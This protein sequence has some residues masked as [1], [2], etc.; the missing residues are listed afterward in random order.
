MSPAPAVMRTTIQSEMTSVPPVTA[1]RSPPTSR[2]TGADS[3]VIAAS[4]TEATPSITSPSD[5]MRSPASTKTT[6]PGF[7]CIAGTAR[8]ADGSWRS[9]V[10][11]R[12]CPFWLRAELAAWALP[13]PSATASAK[14]ANSTVNHSQRD[15]LDR[16]AVVPPRADDEVADEKHRGE[17]RPRPRRR[18]SPGSSTSVTRVEFLEGLTDGRN[19]DLGVRDRGRWGPFACWLLQLERAW[20][21]TSKLKR[22]GRR[23]SRNARRSG[24]ARAP[25]N[26]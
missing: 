5:G 1:E 8:S 4:F 19:Q 16:K 22:F 26:R 25:G 18:T 9:P 6:S 13:R 17:K 12:R 23:S 10:S 7:N 11:W 15:D 14:F 20:I 24:R 21:F 3:P 2:I